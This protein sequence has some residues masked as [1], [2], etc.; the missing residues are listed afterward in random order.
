MVAERIRVTVLSCA[1]AFGAGCASNDA[2][3]S[4]AAGNAPNLG[5]SAG[6]SSAGPGVE[7]GIPGSAGSAALPPEK[8]LDQSFRAPVATGKMLWSANPVSGRV[9][10]ID[11]KT[12]AVRMTNAGF[13]PTYLA[14]VPSKAGT[15]S[16]IVLNTG[17]H[18]ASW[19]VATATAIRVTTIAT[20]VGANAWSISASG[21]YAIAWTD[22]AHLEGG[23]PDAVNGYSELTVIDLSAEPPTST[24]MSVGFR[25]SQVVFDA[26]EAHAFAVVDEGVSVLDLGDSPALAALLSVSSNGPSAHARDVNI[27]AD[28]SFAVVRADGSADVEIIDLASDARRVVT[29]ESSVT[30][31]DLSGDSKRATAILGNATPPKVVSF[32]VPDPSIVATPFETAAINGEL[33]RSV[34]LAPDGKLALLYA[35]AV[36][37]AHLTLL[38]T[39]PGAH[40]YQFRTVDLQGAVQ[41]VF[42]SPDSGTAITFQSPPS[43]SQSR[44]LFSIVP[45][46]VVRAPRIVGTDALPSEIAFSDAAL[47]KALV[48]VHDAT[49]TARGV[50]VIGLAN[51]EQNFVPLSSEPLP[52]ATG[53]VPGAKRGF[54]AQKHPEGRIT[55]IDLDT[56]TAQTLSGFEIAARVVQ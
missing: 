37:S 46:A 53:I 3:P 56:G 2:A 1:L 16:A 14:A 32:A 12:L 51:L 15:D 10:L 33:V 9:A 43:G 42:V 4:S 20:H 50:Y 39:G 47:G 18:D 31:L 44:G 22:A 27:A 5:G 34:S 48:T 25:P 45:T 24:R 35:N 13:G 11:A 7:L 28:G 26:A 52:G 17:S 55:F 30:D 29:L 40:H 54:V 23:A 21:R 19:L 41:S 8:E 6:A 38:D 49:S 36:P